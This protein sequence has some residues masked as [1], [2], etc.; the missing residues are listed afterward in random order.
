MTDS[1][2]EEVLDG[3][4]V[5]LGLAVAVAGALSDAVV[6][7]ILAVSVATPGMVSVSMVEYV[8]PSIIPVSGI[9]STPV[10]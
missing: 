7:G 1:A 2:A 6:T 4:A 8:V 10:A 5:M 9:V 3:A